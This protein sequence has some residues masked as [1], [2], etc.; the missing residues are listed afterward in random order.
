MIGVRVGLAIVTR[1]LVN[2]LIF[3]AQKVYNLISRSPNF[4]HTK[5]NIS[6]ADPFFDKTDRYGELSDDSAGC[7]KADLMQNMWTNNLEYQ[8][9]S[10]YS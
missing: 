10:D 4:I 9:L 5:W 2:P 8:L 6:H 1:R 7:G 3:L